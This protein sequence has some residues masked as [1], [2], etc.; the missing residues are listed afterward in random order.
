MKNILEYFKFRIRQ[1]ENL[2]HDN[3][4]FKLTE[5]KQLVNCLLPSE[6]D[7]FIC[8]QEVAQLRELIDLKD[9]EINKLVVRCIAVENKL[10]DM[11]K[12]L[13]VAG[14]KT[15]DSDNEPYVCNPVFN[16]HCDTPDEYK[17]NPVNVT[18]IETDIES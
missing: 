17:S 6:E 15:L 11:E 12:V 4:A 16:I 1:C 3:M 8:S 18:G 14:L 13:N 2:N 9:V 7:A 5:V 10:A